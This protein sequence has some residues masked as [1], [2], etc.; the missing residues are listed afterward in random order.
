MKLRCCYIAVFLHIFLCKFISAQEPAIAFKNYTEKSIWVKSVLPADGGVWFGANGEL[1]GSYFFLDINKN[2][3]K[4][5]APV[6]GSVINNLKHG[7]GGLWIGTNK[8][9]EF[10]YYNNTPDN[11]SDDSQ[12]SFTKNDGLLSGLIYGMHAD[13]DGI[14]L[15]FNPGGLMYLYTGANP[16][17]KSIIRTTTFPEFSDKWVY[18]ITPDGTGSLW[19][20]TWGNG[21]CYLDYNNTPEITDDDRAICFDVSNGISS[22]V[23][24]TIAIDSSGRKWLATAKGISIITDNGN[25]FNVESIT[26]ENIGTNEGLNGT[27]IYD[28][29][30]D[31]YNRPWVATYGQGV[32]LLDNGKWI[33]Y[34]V[35]N[36]LISD[37]VLGLGGGSAG[38][39]IAT[40]WGGVSYAE[41]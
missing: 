27:D 32:F 41:Y 26:V 10:L 40:F 4:D 19:L 17:D 8:G 13:T 29:V 36:G 1:G 11:K 14:W 12:Q 16:L 37:V 3:Y 7:H 34:T 31:K 30:F 6:T 25:P 28:I 39:F 33:N 15:G 38:M 21:A 35:D 20:S 24:R 5:F 23:V 18:N 2:T 9:L 22:N